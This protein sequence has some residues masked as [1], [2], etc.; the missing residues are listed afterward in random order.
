MY[1]VAFWPLRECHTSSRI[2]FSAEVESKPKSSAIFPE[3]SKGG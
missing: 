1:V 3:G 2:R